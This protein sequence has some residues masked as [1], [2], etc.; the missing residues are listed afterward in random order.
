[1]QRERQPIVAYLQELGEVTRKLSV[2]EIE[3]T[4][5]VLRTA[6]SQGRQVFLL[7][8]GGSASTASHLVNDL[9]KLTIEPGLPRLRAMALTDNV[10]LMTAWANDNAY[11]A[12]FAEQLD[13]FVTAG[14]VVIGISTS[15]NSPNVVRAMKLAKARGAITVAFT[16]HSGG[17]LKAVA[18][19]CF[20]VPSESTQ[21]I[22]DV[23]LAAGH[24]VVRG[25]LSARDRDAS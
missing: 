19:I 25:L 12:I 1:V 6:R 3:R 17:A 23:H 4:I 13:N 15:G 18:E 5:D 11:E 20:M 10:A 9:A 24:C 14:D 7:G 22:E 16:G 21:L 8:N 2:E